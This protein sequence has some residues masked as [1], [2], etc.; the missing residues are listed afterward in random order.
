MYDTRSTVDVLLAAANQA[1]AGG[2]D[3]ADEVAYLQSE[4]D[5][6]MGQAGSLQATEAGA[7]WNEFLQR[8]GWWG[9]AE[10]GA[11]APVEPAEPAETDETTDET[12]EGEAEAPAPAAA[13]APSGALTPTVQ[14]Q[15][16][17]QFFLV[18]F[19]SLLGD[20]SGAN[21]PW[22][23]ETPDPMTTVTWNSWVEINPETAERLDIHHDDMVLVR[24]E[25]GE[26][27]APAY[28][29]PAIRPDVVAIPF[30][31]GH[32]A[33]GR[34][35]EGRGVNP[36]DLVQV[37]QNGEGQLVFGDTLVT[38]EKTGRR[39]PLARLESIKG[40]YEH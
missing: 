5:P 6:L 1:G 23:Q 39:R 38:I 28:V 3:A 21:R 14:V 9:E 20:G 32:T 24:S 25:A 18:A 37:T 15:N 34:Y 8:G 10:N 13:V 29:Y 30:G 17:N 35:A 12:T 7:F 36:M 40:V 11:A 2:V 27:E 4:I 22:L 26:I 16:E 33:M 31:Q 19:P